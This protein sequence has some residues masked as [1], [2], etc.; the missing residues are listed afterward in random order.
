MKMYAEIEVE[1]RTFL[2][3]KPDGQLQSSNSL[4]ETYYTVR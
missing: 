1:L 2:N 3:M 4:L